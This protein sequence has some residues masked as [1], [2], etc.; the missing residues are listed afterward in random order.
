[1][2]NLYIDSISITCDSCNYMKKQTENLDY[3]INKPCWSCGENLLTQ[4]DYDNQIKF[5]SIVS[6][7]NKMMFKGDSQKVKAT[8]TTHERLEIIEIVEVKNEN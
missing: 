8:V 3:Y 7:V 2:T 4:K 1:M 6:E 5:M